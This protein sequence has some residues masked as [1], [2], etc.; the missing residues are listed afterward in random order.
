M[1]YGIFGTAGAALAAFAGWRWLKW[2]NR[3]DYPPAE[4]LIIQPQVDVS[5][6]RQP[7]GALRIDWSLPAPPVAIYTGTQPD[8][9]DTH[10]PLKAHMDGQSAVVD[11]LPGDARHY[12]L[13]EF[14]G[15]TRL[16]AAERTLPLAGAANFRDIGGYTTRDGKRLRW[17]RVYRS[18]QL[19]NLTDGDHRYLAQIGVRLVCDLRAEEEVAEEPDN[20]PGNVT[21]THLPLTTDTDVSRRRRLRAI[22]FNRH[23]LPDV[24]REVYTRLIIDS[25]GPLMGSIMRRLA[26]PE[27]LPAIIHCTAGK[28]RAGVTAALVMLALG[29]PEETVIADY[30]L[31]NRYYA[32]FRDIADKALKPLARFGVK[33]DD[34]YP[35][36]T[37]NPAVLRHALDYMR[38]KYGSVE[39]YLREAAGV[40]DALIA[41]L[42]ANLLE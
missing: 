31:S 15:G 9:I 41:S 1:I 20:L 32:D 11:G 17:G 23:R 8:T 27:N 3:I 30:T 40:D 35:L 26:H 36:I 7:D 33:G 5:V 21:Y 29:V 34:L 38:D 4:S 12:F 10:T 24:M 16:P 14:T 18:G 6:T 37:A 28:D 2:R 39:G 25:N 13:L 19:S 22:L 42:R